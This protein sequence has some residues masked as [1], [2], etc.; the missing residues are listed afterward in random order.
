MIDYSKILSE[1]VSELKPSG[2]RKFFDLAAEVKD[3]IAL[4]IGE[5]NFKTPW[6]I[7]EAGIESLKKGRTWYT[8]NAGLAELRDEASKY[9]K[10]KFNLD[11]NASDIFITVGDGAYREVEF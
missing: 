11:Y 10:R 8:A 2:I 4:T 3:V 6:E 9:L 1:K 7:R 5:P